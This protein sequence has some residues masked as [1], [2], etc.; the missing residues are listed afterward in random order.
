MNKDLSNY[1]QDEL[2]LSKFNS[3]DELIYKIN[4]INITK[5]PYSSDESGDTSSNYS[6]LQNALYKNTIKQ[7]LE[8]SDEIQYN[9]IKKIYVNMLLRSG[10]FWLC[11]EK[12]I[13]K[14]PKL[15]Y[16]VFSK[17]KRNIW[18]INKKN[19]LSNNFNLEL[20][21]IIDTE[22]EFHL[23]LVYSGMFCLIKSDNNTNEN[24]LF[25]PDLIEKFPMI[26]PEDKEIKNK[27]YIEYDI[28][29]I[30]IADILSK[31]ISFELPIYLF[32]RYENNEKEFTMERPLDIHGYNY[33]EIENI[34]RKCE[35]FE[36]LTDIKSIF[37]KLLEKYIYDESKSGRFNHH[38][39][40]KDE[41]NEIFCL[42]V[43]HISKEKEEQKFKI[44]AT[45]GGRFL[46]FSTGEIGGDIVMNDYKKFGFYKNITKIFIDAVRCIYPD[47]IFYLFTKYKYL[48][49]THLDSG[50]IMLDHQ[51]N[52]KFIS[53]Y[54]KNEYHLGKDEMYVFRTPGKLGHSILDNCLSF[55][56]TCQAIYIGD[57]L[58][59]TARHCCCD[60]D[61]NIYLKNSKEWTN[62]ERYSFIK[63]NDISIRIKQ[64]IH[65]TWPEFENINDHLDVN[66]AIVCDKSDKTTLEKH[67]TDEQLEKVLIY[68]N[69][70]T[71][72]TVPRPTPTYIHLY[73]SKM[74]GNRFFNNDSPIIFK[75]I[76][77][78]RVGLIGNDS[79]LSII[80][81]F[82]DKL[83]LLD[84]ENHY[85]L[86]GNIYEIV[87][88]KLN[89]AVI[90]KLFTP[91]DKESFL[92][93][94]DMKYIVKNTV[95]NYNKDFFYDGML[96][97]N[98]NNIKLLLNT[99]LLQFD[100][101][102]NLQDIK[103]KFVELQNSQ[104]IYSLLL[105]S[106][107]KLSENSYII[108]NEQQIYEKINEAI[109]NEEHDIHT[110][111]QKLEEI[112]KTIK[113]KILNF[114]FDNFVYLNKIN[115]I[116]LISID[117][118]WNDYLIMDNT[119]SIHDNDSVIS[120]VFEKKLGKY[121]NNDNIKYEEHTSTG[122]LYKK[123]TISKLDDPTILQGNSGGTFYTELENRPFYVGPVGST[124]FSGG[125]DSIYNQNA[126]IINNFANTLIQLIPSK[127]E[128]MSAF[129]E[130]YNKFYTNKPI[131][132]TYRSYQTLLINNPAHLQHGGGYIYNYLSKVS[133]HS[134]QK[135]KYYSQNDFIY[136]DEEKKL[137]KSAQL[138]QFEDA[139]I[140]DLENHYYVS[141]SVL[142]KIKNIIKN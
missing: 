56:T 61:E 29:N 4:N 87:T 76:H 53:K 37:N 107:I 81:T 71:L 89:Y 141:D 110:K 6:E 102:I 42:L 75:E 31:K 22:Q 104:Q 91:K 35:G 123:L 13:K 125:I 129:M 68:E 126:K 57:G 38:N 43:F 32:F 20:S 24:Y 19:L 82:N 27:L 112:D 40:Y 62:P 108:G 136:V 77:K 115:K 66:F 134:L 51:Y 113:S 139:K 52:N 17:Q 50:L 83:E 69:P 60:D 16:L 98:L 70:E 67:I 138:A 122:D 48:V 7:N 5:I 114:Y 99:L 121:N 59:I 46:Y 30:S 15:Q 3:S 94:K 28:I 45:I 34:F 73:T 116:E 18:L 78:S 140:E 111:I 130:E 124:A 109:T 12:S 93:R 135:Y 54:T 64:Q 128:T 10:I 120:K 95:S 119:L 2:N 127:Q 132:Y 9:D 55:N 133:E 101:K 65:K 23:D 25:N 39:L 58:F 90:N 85:K 47:N 8:E 79:D 131:V 84:N 142:D 106:D 14:Y 118:Q 96:T 11:Y 137:F 21:D 33:N 86:D 1:I 117:K 74:I 26:K 36:G 97:F 100:E 92:F 72:G 88:D 80:K 105:F 63:K 103:V 49:K 41:N 44:K